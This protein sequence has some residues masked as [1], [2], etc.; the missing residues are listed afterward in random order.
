[1]ETGPGAA[2]IVVPGLASR[3][4]TSVLSQA[5]V[6]VHWLLTFIASNFI[7]GASSHTVS[8]YYTVFILELTLSIMEGVV[9]S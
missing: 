6:R 5:T 2:Y 3:L 9:L 4:L 7:Y 8:C 1:M